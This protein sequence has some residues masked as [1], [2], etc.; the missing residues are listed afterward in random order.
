MSTLRVIR[1]NPTAEEVA[2]LV[3]VLLRSRPATPAEPPRRVGGWNDR[4]AAIG[5]PPAPGPGA[6][7][8]ATR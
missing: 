3:A 2:A 7:R 8:A 1:G 5:V 4:A 6:W